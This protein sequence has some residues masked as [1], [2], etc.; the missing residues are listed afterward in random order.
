MRLDINLASQPYEDA[1]Q[2]WLRWGSGLV[3]TALITLLL[4]VSTVT[5]WLNARRD[6]AQIAGLREQI[7]ERDQ[8]RRHAEET[9]RLPENRSTRDDSQ[10]INRLIERKSFSWTQV[11]QD[12]EKV[13]PPR[14]HLV[15]I[16]PELDEENQLALKMLVAGDSS[17]RGIDLAQRMEAS[18][19]FAQ[20][21]IARVTTAQNTNAGDAVQLDIDA[22]YIPQPAPAAGA[23]APKAEAPQRAGSS[24]RS[25]S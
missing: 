8:K 18:G 12:L 15:S 20:T 1:R 16:H 24:K 2:F 7:A 10:F 13:M 11:L 5:G 21:H 6:R 23:P 19:R 4:L 17:Q 22:I 3:L 25:K 14:V 9:L